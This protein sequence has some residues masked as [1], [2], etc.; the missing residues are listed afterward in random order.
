M[1]QIALQDRSF[2]PYEALAD[3]SR[4]LGPSRAAFGASAHFVGTLRNHNE[5]RVVDRLWLE[6]YPSMTEQAIARLVH[7][8]RGRL[9][10]GPALV[11][12]RVGDV[13]P[14]E[15]LVVIAVWSMHRRASLEGCR[16]LIERLKH[17]AP[18]WKQEFGSWG[19]AWVENNT[20]G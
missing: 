4:A 20:L 8:E 19:S 14:G 17:E 10:F 5:G 12:H 11:W 18:F 15:T 3:F 7:E 9:N 1:D 2:D 16:V 13:L 6:H